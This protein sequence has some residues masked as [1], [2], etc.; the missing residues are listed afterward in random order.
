MAGQGV[1]AHGSTGERWRVS[2]GIFVSIPSR[3]SQLLFVA[4]PPPVLLMA[5]LFQS[6]PGYPSFCSCSPSH[7]SHGMPLQRYFRA[8]LAWRAR[9]YLGQPG[10]V[11]GAYRIA[12]NLKR[13]CDC[14]RLQGIS[15]SL[16]S[17]AC[18][19]IRGPSGARTR[20]LPPRA[21]ADPVLRDGC[22]RL[23][24]QCARRW[25]RALGSV[26]VAVPDHLAVVVIAP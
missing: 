10:R 12:M 23:H 8:S 25:R 17:S 1:R 2:Q 6:L 7:R 19:I 18:R 9:G 3:V 15:C 26:L 22:T 24:R 21:A 4:S 11:Q 14:E 5:L 20:V 16:R 13:I